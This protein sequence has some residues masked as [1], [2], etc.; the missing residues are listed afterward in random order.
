[1]TLDDFIIHVYCMIEEKIEKCLKG[2][3]LRKAGFAPRLTDGEALTLEVVGE[4]LG[5]HQDK[6]IW[7]Y[8]KTHFQDW[9]PEL[10]SRT[11]FVEQCANLKQLKDM[12]LSDLFAVPCLDDLHMVDGFPIPVMLLARS[13]RDRCYKGEAAHGYCASKDMHYYGFLGHVMIDSEGRLAGF[14]LTPA[15]GSER[16]ALRHMAQNIQG[17]VLADKGFI[18]EPLKQELAIQGVNLQTPLRDNM[19]DERSKQWVKWIVSTR[20]LVETV[21]G[22]LTERFAINAIKAK[23]FWHL[24]AKIARKLL[25]HAIATSLAKANGLNPI[26]LEALVKI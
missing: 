11:S 7:R 22:Q 2:H 13:R 8:F 21:I 18:S 19:K 12:L 1:M 5:L 6:Q 9:F 24:Q 3:K 4:Y 23:S 15:N 10:R 14:M 25:S 17:M 16:E 20:R 26:T